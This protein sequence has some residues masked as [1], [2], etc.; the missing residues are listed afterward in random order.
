MG[1]EIILLGLNH[2]T[3]SV[4]TR[5][6]VAF[7]EPEKVN[8]LN[9]LLEWHFCNGVVILNTCNRTE[10]YMSTEDISD[11][12]KLLVNNFSEYLNGNLEDCTYFLENGKVADH[13][14]RVAS[15][16]DSMIQGEPQI[17]GQVRDAYEFSA[18]RGF[19]ST[20][21]HELFNRAIRT[22]KRAR[23]ETGISEKAASVA[24]AAVELLKNEISDLCKTKA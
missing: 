12:K 7:S 23:T 17:L 9:K 19:C 10:I 14:F 5:E 16:L 13:L 1:Q 4:G 18:G 6:Q 22:G 8:F 2:K 11:G 3:A 15:G 20:Y 24:Y 21:L